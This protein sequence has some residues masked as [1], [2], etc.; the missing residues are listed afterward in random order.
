MDENSKEKLWDLYAKNKI[1]AENLCGNELL[2]FNSRHIPF[3][4]GC[5]QSY[6]ECRNHSAEHCERMV[7][8]QL[9]HIIIYCTAGNG[10][11]G[12]YSFSQYSRKLL[13]EKITHYTSTDT[14]CHRHQYT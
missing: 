9:E 14:G 4:F 1:T 11:K 6:D 8:V 7:Y 5:K 2:L 10:S 3:I 13:A 12:I